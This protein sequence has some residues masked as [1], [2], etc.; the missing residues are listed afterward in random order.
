MKILENI[1]NEYTTLDPEADLFFLEFDEQIGSKIL[2][3][4]SQH[5]PIASMLSKCGFEVTGV[6]LRESDQELNYSHIKADFCQLS[7]PYSSFD[8]AVSVSTIEHFGL[9]HHLRLGLF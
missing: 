2:E 5:V 4:G 1:R 8:V 6:D 7:F 9:G 3:I